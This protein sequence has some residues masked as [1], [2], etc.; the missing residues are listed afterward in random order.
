VADREVQHLSFARACPTG[1]YARKNIG[2]LAAMAAKAP[3]II[4]TDDDNWPL[5]T[6]WQKRSED[7][8][9][10]CLDQAGWTNVYRYFTDALIWP[11]GLPLRYVRRQ[12]PD[13]T[14]LAQFQTVCPIQQGLVDGNP[15]VDAVYRLVLPLPQV[16]QNNVQLALGPGSWCPF[17]SQNTVWWPQAYPLLY[18]PSH[19]SFRMTDIWRSFIAQRIAWANGWRV[20]FHGATVMQER[21]EHDLISDF[22]HEIPGYLHNEKLALLLDCLPIKPGVADTTHNLSLCYRELIANGCIGPQEMA[23]LDCWIADCA[24]LIT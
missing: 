4:E 20:L 10:R 17:N 8:S 24:R 13:V 16:F 14:S 6:F 11:R 15:D 3:F 18:L 19:C 5:P 1:T 12:V 21:N 23:I 9:V 2:Y 7:A 22:E